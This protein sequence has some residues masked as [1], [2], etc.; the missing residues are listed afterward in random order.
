MCI[1][2]AK[3]SF[4][5]RRTKLAKIFALIWPLTKLMVYY[6]IDLKVREKTPYLTLGMT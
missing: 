3:L 4:A 5:G 6:K 1:V 2:K